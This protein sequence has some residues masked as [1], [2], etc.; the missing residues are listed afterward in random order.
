MADEDARRLLDEQRALTELLR[1]APLPDVRWNRLAETIS[2]AID[3]DAAQ[4][5][6]RASWVLRLGRPIP[7]AAAALVLLAAGIAVHFFFGPASPVVATK[8]VSSSPARML[9]V[10]GPAPDQPAGPAVAEVSISPGGSYAK[11]PPLAPYMDEIDTRPARV[12]IAS[13]V[14]PDERAGAFPF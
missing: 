10:R 3:D 2:A 4:R 11:E 1:S 8:P 5:V 9:V 14:T 13:G 12:L 7:L 6:T